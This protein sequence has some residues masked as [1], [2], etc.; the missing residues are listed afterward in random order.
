M[1]DAICVRILQIRLAEV[2]G[3]CVLLAVAALLVGLQ[4]HSLA[5]VTRSLDAIGARA[6]RNHAN[7][8][9]HIAINDK[10]I[11]DQTLASVAKISTLEQLSLS[12]STLGSGQAK[13]FASM[14]SLQTLTLCDTNISSYELGYVGQ[15]RNLEILSLDGT[16]IGKAGIRSL[17]KLNGLRYL[18]LARTDIGNSCVE[19]LT[20]LHALEELDL[21][22]TNVTPSAVARLRGDLPDCHITTDAPKTS[23]QDW[24]AFR[25]WWRQHRLSM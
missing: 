17:A 12:R 10:R 7:R 2:V 15:C 1:R 23:K 11:V 24:I 16:P 9:Y 13:H 14:G 5:E 25:R 4:R 20:K 8:I 21:R 18:S 6:H 22:G 3:T 19:A